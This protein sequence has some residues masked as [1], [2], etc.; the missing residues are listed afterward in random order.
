MFSKKKPSQDQSSRTNPEPIPLVMM[1]CAL[2]GT[3]DSDGQ[4]NTHRK[5]SSRP[6]SSGSHTSN[7]SQEQGVS[8]PKQ[9]S[10]N[11][12]SS[13]VSSE[14]RKPILRE[15][16]STAS[17]FSICRQSDS[18]THGQGMFANQSLSRG[19]LILREAPLVRWAKNAVVPFEHVWQGYISL[20]TAQRQRWYQL[21]HPQG[22]ER[23]ARFLQVGGL[24][25]QH[26]LRGVEVAGLPTQRKLRAEIL[27][28]WENNSFGDMFDDSFLCVTGTRFNHRYFACF[29]GPEKVGDR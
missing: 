4:S 15:P 7:Q 10:S 13:N 20:P 23:K 12:G 11:S 25:K 1:S 24:P 14:R 8:D 18:P 5:Q 19:D 6:P 9:P 16:A 21:T 2:P 27:A 3:A 28:K 22:A 26:R 17:L 29:C